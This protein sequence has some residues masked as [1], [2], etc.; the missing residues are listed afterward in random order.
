MKQVTFLKHELRN[1]SS[2]DFIFTGAPDGTE[3]ETN[4]G[5]IAHLTLSVPALLVSRGSEGAVFPLSIIAPTIKAECYAVDIQKEK[6]KKKKK[7]T[8]KKP[9]CIAGKNLW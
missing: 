2:Y 7:K 8:T 9:L 3:E 5:P 6:E 1:G 4:W